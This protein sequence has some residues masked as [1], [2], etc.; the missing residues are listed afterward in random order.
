MKQ[1]LNNYQ[2][3]TPVRKTTGN[4]YF[5]SHMW[6]R[7]ER[8]TAIVRRWG[9]RG[10]KSCVLTPIIQTSHHKTS[11]VGQEWAS[12]LQLQWPL[13][14]QSY[15]VSPC[16]A[17]FSLWRAYSASLHQVPWSHSLV[18]TD[19]PSTHKASSSDS[20]THQRAKLPFLL[21]YKKPT[22]SISQ[23]RKEKKERIKKNFTE[24][25]IL[26]EMRSCLSRTW[27]LHNG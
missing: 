6:L 25:S 23:K 20:H 26:T 1:E 7:K 13:T 8:R 16:R 3:Q 21:C 17:P 11:H 24:D 22:L 19:C 5:N 4:T 15:L 14:F 27:W 12:S 10:G 2:F 9:E 18:N